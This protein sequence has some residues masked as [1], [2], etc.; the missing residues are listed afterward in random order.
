MH[1]PKPA[2]L[3]GLLLAA[4]CASGPPR[5]PAPRYDWILRGGTVYDGTGAPGRVSDVGIRGDRVASV[6]DLSAASAAQTLDARGLAV[7][8]GFINMLSWAPDAL[9]VDGRSLGDIKQGVTLE[10]FGEGWSYCCFLTSSFSQ[11]L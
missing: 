11:A 6:G 8:P 2:V 4:S 1:V 5:A 9:M 3:L 10:I 7:S